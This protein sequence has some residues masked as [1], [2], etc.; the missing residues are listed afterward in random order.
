ME[1]LLKKANELEKKYV[2]LQA[3]EYFSKAFHLALGEKNI[4]ETAEILEKLGFSESKYNS[5]QFYKFISNGSKK[6]DGKIYADLRG[7][8]YTPIWDNPNPLMYHNN[9]VDF[10]KYMQ[11]VTMVV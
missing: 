1:L 2:W 10:N 7:T 3:T 8:K 11:K 6:K 5:N 4:L 9:N